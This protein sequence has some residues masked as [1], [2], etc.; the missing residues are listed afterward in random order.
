[1]IL[2]RR[3]RH[4][5]SNIIFVLKNALTILIM[6]ISASC[7]FHDEKIEIDVDLSWILKDNTDYM[8]SIVLIY[9]LYVCI[10]RNGQLL[11][12]NEI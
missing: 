12:F 6:N 1:M 9:I 5:M 4:I 7:N 8:S 10:L 2:N 3:N 11:E